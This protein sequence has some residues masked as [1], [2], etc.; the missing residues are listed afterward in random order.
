MQLF[1]HIRKSP[2]EPFHCELR[3]GFLLNFET[4]WKKWGFVP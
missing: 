1:I 2:A 3:R 4:Q